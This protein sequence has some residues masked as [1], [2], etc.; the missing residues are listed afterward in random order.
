MFHFKY[1][2][3]TATLIDADALKIIRDV[4]VLF[5]VEYSKVRKLIS[6]FIR[7]SKELLH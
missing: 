5:K 6:Q 3:F 4:Q 2:Y 1:K 7:H